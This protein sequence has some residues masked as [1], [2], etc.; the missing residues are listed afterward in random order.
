MFGKRVPPFLPS[1]PFRTGF[2]LA[3]KVKN[4]LATHGWVTHTRLLR[5]RRPDIMS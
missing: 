3:E 2:C 1:L 5:M 4:S